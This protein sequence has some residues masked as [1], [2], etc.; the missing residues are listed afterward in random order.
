[1]I[2]E[3]PDVWIS[4][5]KKHEQYLCKT[6]AAYFRKEYLA[7]PPCLL[8]HQVKLFVRRNLRTIVAT[9]TRNFSSVIDDFNHTFTTDDTKQSTQRDEALG[10]LK[11][12]FN[13]EKFRDSRKIWG[14]YLLCECSVYKVCP[15]CHLRTI[16]TNPKSDEL[17][18]YRPDLDHYISQSNYPFL[19]LS[20]GNIMP[21]CSKCNGPQM[22]HDTDFYKVPHLNPQVDKA[23]LSF[24]LLPASGKSW[25]PELRALRGRKK[26]YLIHIAA[27]E[28]NIAASRSLTTFQLIPQYQ[29]HLHEAWRIAKSIRKNLSFAKSVGQVTGLNI[30]S[31]DQAEEIET[32]LG[33]SPDREDFRNIPLGKMMLDVWNDVQSWEIS[34]SSQGLNAFPP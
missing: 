10:M 6:I 19:A 9:S 22:K 17:T 7:G 30:L 11:N 33:F 31:Q 28:G 1:M 29:N 4:A 21:S 25:S 27:P 12:I 24:S 18:G 23:V 3:I 15:Y 16:D 8:L 5:A 14:A 32:I 20:L 13:Y 2:I 34:S 26:D